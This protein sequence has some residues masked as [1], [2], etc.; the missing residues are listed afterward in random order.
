MISVHFQ[1]K[2]FNITVIQVCAP[3]TDAKEVEIDQFCEDLQDLLQ[4]IPNKRCLFHHRGLEC[5]SRKSR[6]N[7]QV[8][9]WNTKW[10]RAKASRMLSGEHISHS[11]PFSQQP[12]RWLCTWTSPG[13]QYWN[14]FDYILC[15]QRRR[16]SIQSA[17][18]RPEADCGSDHKLLI[19]NQA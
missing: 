2:S 4:L 6:N 19:A 7:R 15:S 1:G 16:S 17:K 13:G 11:K 12:K 18:T 5:K 14:Q 3:T 10:I 9:P 8:W